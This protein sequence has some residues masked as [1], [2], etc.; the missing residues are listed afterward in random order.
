MDRNQE[1][2]YIQRYHPSGS[3]CLVEEVEE[4]SI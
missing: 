2:V 4:C 3:R 1:Y